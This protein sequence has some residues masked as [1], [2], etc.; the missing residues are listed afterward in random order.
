VYLCICICLQDDWLERLVDLRALLH[1]GQ[2]GLH[3]VE[4]THR[5]DRLLVTGVRRLEHL[6][7]V[8]IMIIM[9]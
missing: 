9:S 3:R 6:I 2:D 7:I 8:M 1:H 5:S 4:E